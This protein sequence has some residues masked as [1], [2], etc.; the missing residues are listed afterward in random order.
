MRLWLD[1]QIDDPATPERHTPDGYVG[2]KTAIQACRLLARHRVTL[3]DFDHDLGDAKNGTGYLVARFIEHGAYTHRIGP[4]LHHIHSANPV[5]RDNI[6][7]AMRSAGR[8]WVA[9]DPLEW[10]RRQ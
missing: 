6:E 4:L 5:G 8:K 1:D 2:V 10:R 3:I 9:D 7:R